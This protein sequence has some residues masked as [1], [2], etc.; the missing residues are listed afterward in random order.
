MNPN[1]GHFRSIGYS[2]SDDFIHW[3]P[4]R[5]MLEV[6]AEDRVDFQPLLFSGSRLKA[7]MDASLPHQKTVTGRGTS[8]AELRTP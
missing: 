4:T 8:D 7:D 5:L 1:A 2:E 3:S 6:D